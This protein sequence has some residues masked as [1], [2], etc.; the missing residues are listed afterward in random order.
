MAL[1]QASPCF[2]CSWGVAPVYG[3]K[4]R[5]PSNQKTQ[6][7]NSRRGLGSSQV[8]GLKKA[9]MEPRDRL[10]A[11]ADR[12]PPESTPLIRPF[13]RFSHYDPT[14]NRGGPA[15]RIDVAECVSPKRHA[16][17]SSARE[18]H[19]V[20]TLRKQ[21]GTLQLFVS[22]LQQSVGTLRKTVF[23]LQLFVGTVQLPVGTLRQTFRTVTVGSLPAISAN[24]TIA[25]R[26]AACTKASGGRQSP[27]PTAPASSAQDASRNPNHRPFSPLLPSNVVARLRQRHTRLTESLPCSPRQ[28][29]RPPIKPT[30][31]H[32]PTDT[33]NSANNGIDITTPPDVLDTPTPEDYRAPWDVRVNIAISPKGT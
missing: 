1:G 19:R 27:D 25:P 22:P 10:S 29:V 13:K 23:P 26:Q 11:P 15:S 2:P 32:R 17:H 18:K 5:W 20:G 9:S 21:V 3:E 7:Q 16:Q 4:G 14:Q 8:R 28:P 6:L 33:A 30:H 12:V 24:P 31:D